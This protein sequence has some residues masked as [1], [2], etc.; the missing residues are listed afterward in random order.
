MKTK[1]IILF[2]MLYQLLTASAF[3]QTVQVTSADALSIAQN[4]FEGQDVDYYL[5]PDSTDWKIFVDAEPLL[6]WAHDCYIL[7]IPKSIAGSL[8]QIT[9]DSQYMNFPPATRME[10]LAVV[11]RY[12]DQTYDRPQVQKSNRVTISG[13]SNL[14][15]YAVIINGGGNME[16]NS[17][18]FWNDCAFIFQTLKYTYGVPQR[19]IRVLMADGTDPEID[20]RKNGEYISQD[21]DLDGDGLDD[22]Q[23]AATKKNVFNVLEE[24][25]HT[26]NQDDHLLLFVTDHGGIEDGSPA[27]ALWNDGSYFGGSIKDYELAQHLRPLTD[28]GITVNVVMGQCYSGGFVEP[29]AEIGCI[30]TTSCDK[31]QKAAGGNSGNPFLMDWTSTINGMNPNGKIVNADY[32]N[33][34]Y[35]SMAEA[36]KWVKENSIIFISNARQLPQFYGGPGGYASK[37]A[38]NKL[39]YTDVLLKDKVDNNGNVANYATA[40]AWKSPSIIVLNGQE[41]LTIPVNDSKFVNIFDSGYFYV[42]V[43]NEGEKTSSKPLYLNTFYALASTALNSSVWQGNETFS[44]KPTGGLISSVKVGEIPAEG[45][46]DVKVIV[47]NT[48][49]SKFELSIMNSICIYAVLSDTPI[50][51]AK[52]A[53]FLDFN[54]LQKKNEAQKS[55]QFLDPKLL[56]KPNNIIVRNLSETQSAIS[57]ELLP[58]QN[59]T[60]NIFNRATVSVEL[61]SKLFDGWKEGGSQGKNIKIDGNKIMLQNA[62]NVINNIPMSGKDRDDVNIKFSFNTVPSIPIHYSFDLIQ[63]DSEGKVQGGVTIVVISPYN[64]GRSI[65]ID[66][67][68]YDECQIQLTAT[69]DFDI[70]CWTDEYGEVNGDSNSII[71]MPTMGS[72]SYSVAAL[73]EDGEYAV[74]EITIDNPMGIESITVNPTEIEI[75]FRKTTCEN[76]HIRLMN[77]QDS[78]LIKS[79]KLPA[80]D[81]RYALYI[82][83]CKPGL[84]IVQYIIGSEVV[85]VKKVAI[86]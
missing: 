63:K 74:G 52:D 60:D 81:K 86:Q 11:N 24:L 85:D 23:Y 59:N 43:N 3:A 44:G 50:K 51:S 72:N 67:A 8:S 41:G 40:G 61:S 14:R 10:P 33:D 38:F 30:V 54:P 80:G 55:V 58:S 62:Q 53:T 77:T 28:N 25:A 69:D 32:D 7:T 68:K 39:P 9:P 76:S 79:E 35:I 15:T 29:L 36:F 5:I 13:N 84:Y 16:L 71:I 1:I 64:Q 57:L 45:Y 46:K 12:K 4:Q 31:G 20:M 49:L 56:I 42:R 37:L 21:L 48:I 83:D 73:T 18:G 47:E 75:N 26:M 65:A 70:Y 6:G 66:A 2:L 78:S 17:P 34:G 82:A 19:N 27:F 22:I